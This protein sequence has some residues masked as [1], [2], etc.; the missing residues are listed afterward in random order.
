M[1]LTEK[2]WCLV[3]FTGTISVSLSGDRELVFAEHPDSSDYNES[4]L[5]WLKYFMLR[6]DNWILLCGKTVSQRGSNYLWLSN[7]APTSHSLH[8][9]FSLSFCQTFLLLKCSSNENSINCILQKDLICSI[10]Y[11]CLWDIYH[12][13]FFNKMFCLW[14]FEKTLLLASI[15]RCCEITVYICLNLC[16]LLHSWIFKWENPMRS[17]FSVI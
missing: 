10:A 2:I 6:R 3:A 15:K 7:S 5:I 1:R 17:G 13:Y 8:R 16:S 14:T 12:R 9:V 4:F 11:I